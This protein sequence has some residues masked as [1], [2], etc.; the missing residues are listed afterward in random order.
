M[1]ITAPLYW[2]SEYDT[3]KVGTVANSCSKMHKLLYKP[4]EMS[5]F[6]FDKLPGFKNEIKSFRPKVDEEVELWKRIDA[7][8]DVSNQGRIRH[9]K[10]ILSGSVHSDN[11]ILVTLHS[12][13]IPIH[14]LVAEAFIPN[15]EKKPE[16][17]HIDGNK[18]NN[19]ADNLEWTTRAENQKHAVDNGLQPKPAKTY[20]GKFTAEQRDEIKRLWDSGM[21]SK[22]RLSKKFGVSHTCINDIINDKYKYAGSVNLFEEVARPIVDT[23]NELRDSYFSCENDVSQKQIWYSILQLLPESYN[24]RRTVTMTYENVM[25]MLDY[26]EG[27][28]LDEWREFCKILKQLPYVNEIRDNRI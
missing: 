12:K 3:Y 23:L 2:W 16:V 13:Q 24:Q 11:Y 20:Q 8:Y 19:A 10:R 22:R 26:R 27:H 14:R 15:Y 1:D 18:M 5:D 9:G 6:S 25:N 21:F 28:K 7:E 17:N 4:F